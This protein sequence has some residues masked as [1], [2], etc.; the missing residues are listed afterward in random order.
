[1]SSIQLTRFHEAK[2]SPSKRVT[3]CKNCWSDFLTNTEIPAGSP[4]VVVT[5][6]WGPSTR[7]VSLCPNCAEIE[8]IRLERLARD[9]RDAA[10]WTSPVA[11]KLYVLDNCP[12]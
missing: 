2:F 6:G 4:R 3:R 1:M 12:F 10:S 5:G 8:A 9:I 11:R 7:H